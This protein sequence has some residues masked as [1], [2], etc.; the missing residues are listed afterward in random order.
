MKLVKTRPVSL[1]PTLVMV[2]V[3][4][5]FATLGLLIASAFM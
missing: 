5:C 1:S 4:L 2:L 3:F